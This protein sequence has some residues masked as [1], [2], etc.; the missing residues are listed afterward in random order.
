MLVDSHCHLDFPDF[1]GDLEEVVGRARQAGIVRMVTVCTRPSRLAASLAIAERFPD[2]FC[3]CGLH[4]HDAATEEVGVD[5]LTGLADHP[6]LAAI[7]ECGLDYHYDRSPRPA[8]QDSFR[9]HVRAARETGLP[10]VVHT[11][12]ADADTTRIL[13]EEAAGEGGRP[14]VR[15]VMHCFSSGRQL[16]ED[17]LALGF[18]IS[19]SGILTFNRS[20]ELREIARDVPLDRLLVETD[21]PYLAPVPRRGKRNEPA[22]VTHTA[23]RL[24]EVKGM[25]I[26]ALARQTTANFFRLFS[27]VPQPASAGP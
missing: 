27:K 7:G 14:P 15:G 8:Q 18:Y 24:A 12:E 2:V 13:R 23:A 10:L 19:F 21:A 6:K 11:R 22:L 25:T 4:P 20:E 9:I 16:A 1:E 26:D 3:A 17:A 5:T